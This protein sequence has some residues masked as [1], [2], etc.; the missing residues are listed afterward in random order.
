M[1]NERAVC[2]S[3][4]G[5]LALRAVKIEL[6]ARARALLL[7]VDF[8]ASR[9]GVKKRVGMRPREPLRIGN[10]AASEGGRRRRAVRRRLLIPVSLRHHRGTHH[11]GILGQQASHR[12]RRRR[13]PRPAPGQAAGELRGRGL[14]PPPAGLQPDDPR[15]LPEVPAGA[16]LRRPVPRGGVLRRDRDQPDAAGDALLH[17]PRH[18]REPDGGRPAG[19]R[20]RSSSP[21]A[22]RAAIRAT[23][24][25]T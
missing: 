7:R 22:R 4:S 3:S 18:G 5:H 14:R 8:P 12:H 17:E 2:E 23:S 10:E 24:K 21:S 20:S 15:R 9:A 11:E 16:P 13:V 19:R 6:M 25:A 1:I